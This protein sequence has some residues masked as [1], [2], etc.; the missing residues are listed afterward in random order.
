MRHEGV[1]RGG[2]REF[3]VDD[4]VEQNFSRAVWLGASDQACL[5]VCRNRTF[6]IPCVRFSLFRFFFLLGILEEG[7]ERAHRFI[8]EA[9]FL[10]NVCIEPYPFLCLLRYVGHQ[11]DDERGILAADFQLYVFQI[12][13]DPFQVLDGEVEKR[14]VFEELIVVIDLRRYE[15]ALPVL[16][17]VI[18]DG[19]LECGDEFR[20]FALNGEH[21][22]VRAAEPVKRFLKRDDA[23]RIFR[24]EL[25]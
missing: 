2:P 15:I 25:R 21:E 20:I 5:E 24:K 12:V 19:I 4:A 17:N 10:R 22:A 9:E 23:R 14:V 8:G 16:V 18:V 7:V 13:A 1:V 11:V 6:L 3:R